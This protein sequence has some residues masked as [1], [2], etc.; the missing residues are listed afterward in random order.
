MTNDPSKLAY[1]EIH[2]NQ[3]N[4]MIAAALP[5]TPQWMTDSFKELDED[6]RKNGPAA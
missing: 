5:P 4:R 2:R 3:A 1:D 6:L